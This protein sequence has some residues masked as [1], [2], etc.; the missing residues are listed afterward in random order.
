MVGLS[1]NEPGRGGAVDKGSA[2]AV[3]RSLSRVTK[4]RTFDRRSGKV[5]SIM[6]TRRNAIGAKCV[7]VFRSVPPPPVFLSPPP[8]F[9]P[10]N[11]TLPSRP[12]EWGE[13]IKCAVEHFTIRRLYRR[14]GVTPGT[15]VRPIESLGARYLH[16][17]ST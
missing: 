15:R 16:A 13:V 1:D 4:E 12:S 14:R 8:Q 9:L 7:G 17:V 5:L 11:P 3:G 6:E 10:A 2:A